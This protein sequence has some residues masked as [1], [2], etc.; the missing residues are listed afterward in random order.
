MNQFRNLLDN[1]LN[2]HIVT[3]RMYIIRK[4]CTM[5]TCQ[6]LKNFVCNGKKIAGA[7]VN[8]K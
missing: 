8:Y 4:F 7:G 2:K 6:N 5:D 1:L 3:D